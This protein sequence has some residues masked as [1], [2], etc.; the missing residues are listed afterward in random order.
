MTFSYIIDADQRVIFVRA[1]GAAKSQDIIDFRSR[2]LGEPEF[3]PDFKRLVD[4]TALT[5]IE[6]SSADVENLARDSV[7]ETE[8]RRAFVVSS[9]LHFGL[10]RMFNTYSS[11]TGSANVE[12]FRDLS[13]AIDWIGVPTAVAEQAFLNPA[14][15]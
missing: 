9:V 4:L 6:L 1:L 2:L 3:N 12:V 15:A 10:G 8:A 7:L 11:F 13:E 14:S 5:E